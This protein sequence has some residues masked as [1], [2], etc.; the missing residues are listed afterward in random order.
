MAA[1]P[2]QV[3]SQNSDFQQAFAIVS[4]LLEEVKK[5]VV[6]KDYEIS[7]LITALLSGTHVLIEDVPG[8]GKTTLASTLA[9]AAGMRFNR[10]QFTPDVM[11]SDLTGFNLYNREKEQ[12]VFK[13]GAVM[14]NMLLADEI[15]RASPKTQS[16]LLEAMEEKSVTVDGVTYEIPKPFFVIATQNPTGSVGTYPLPEAQIDRF[17]MKLSMG[18][19]GPQEEVAIIARRLAGNPIKVVAPVCNAETIHHISQLITKVRV[20]ESILQY[21]VALIAATR[22]HPAIALGASPRATVAL[23]HISR[24]YAFMH[25]RAYV[26][27][28]DIS[29]LFPQTICHRLQ[30]TQEAR[31]SR[32]EPMTVV[33]EVLASVRPPVR[34]KR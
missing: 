21:I 30:L 22:Q 3:P 5:V 15:N 24:A 13:Q 4:G 10:V 2:N 1:T 26:I 34:S 33:R 6:G 9:K 17:G 18:Y 27:P 20:E 8:T 31:M 7:M 28:E 25:H 32:I 23:M 29:E 12:F 14:C 19:P 11:A 16:S